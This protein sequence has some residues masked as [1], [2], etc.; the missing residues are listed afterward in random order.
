MARP[1]ERIPIFLELL[2]WP[3]FVYKYHI[4]CEAG[5]FYMLYI[6]KIAYVWSENPDWR[7]GQLL[8]NLRLVPDNPILWTI[9]DGDIL[10]EQEVGFREYLLWG[11][12]GLDSDEKTKK[13]KKSRKRFG[14]SK[15]DVKIDPMTLVFSKD[16]QSKRLLY[17]LRAWLNTNPKAVYKPIKEV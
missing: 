6:A 16:K 4:N 14:L 13:W 2:N 17:A 11:T 8:I 3:E 10:K 9:E 7:F 1:K 5:K 12:Y 15:E